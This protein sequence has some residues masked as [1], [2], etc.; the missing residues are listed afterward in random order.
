MRATLQA[1]DHKIVDVAMESG[2]D[3]H[4]GFTR[5]FA[6]QFGITPRRRWINGLS[7]IPLKPTTF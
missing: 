7:I 2:F 4:D 6:R 3:S 5:A 1:P